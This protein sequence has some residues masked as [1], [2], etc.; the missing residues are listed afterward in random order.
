MS[1]LAIAPTGYRTN[2]ALGDPAQAL[3]SE[4]RFASAPLGLFDL[5]IGAVR[6]CEDAFPTRGETLRH[7]HHLIERWVAARLLAVAGKPPLYTLER[8]CLNM[9]SPPAL[10][11]PARPI[12]FPRRTQ[13]QR[14]W[15]AMKVLRSFDL[16]TLLMAAQANRASTLDMLRVLTRAGW[17]RQTATGWST[18]ADRLWGTV[19]PTFARLN[20]GDGPIIRVTDQR[21]GTVI[22]LPVR[23]RDRRDRGLDTASSAVVDGGVS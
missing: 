15:T 23:P 22:D 5:I 14:L 18:A 16:P 21:D 1:A 13:R 9:A 8:S 17:L 20:E 7:L 12:P 4:L 11:A 2:P 19:S 10:P 6:H 3:W